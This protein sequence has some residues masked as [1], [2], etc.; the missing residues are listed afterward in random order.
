MLPLL[1][2]LN[3]L[4]EVITPSYGLVEYLLDTKTAHFILIL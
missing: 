3:T 2:W 4:V 1:I